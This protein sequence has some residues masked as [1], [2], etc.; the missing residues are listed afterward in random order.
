MTELEY[1]TEL[2]RE[3]RRAELLAQLAQIEGRTGPAEA[4]K[5]QLRKCPMW[6]VKK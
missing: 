1:Y 2:R 4:K 3:Q 5:E 6:K